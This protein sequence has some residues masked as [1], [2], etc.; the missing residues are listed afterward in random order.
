MK[1][2]IPAWVLLDLRAN[3]ELAFMVET[4]TAEEAAQRGATNRAQECMRRAERLLRGAIKKQKGQRR[5]FLIQRIALAYAQ[6]GNFQKAF[7]SLRQYE[8][9]MSYYKDAKPNTKDLTLLGS[10]K[11]ALVDIA[12]IMLERYGHEVGAET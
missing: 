4:A 12:K 7:S 2:G 5:E 9:G 6:M 8:T 3:K 1:K 10:G 11:Q